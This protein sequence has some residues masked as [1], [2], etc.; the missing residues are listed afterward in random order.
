MSWRVG[1]AF[2]AEWTPAAALWFFFFWRWFDFWKTR[3]DL[4]YVMLGTTFVV[5]GA[6]LAAAHRVVLA[7][8]VELLLWVEVIG[9]LV[10]ALASAFVLVADRQIG[11]RVRSFA[12]FFDDVGHLDLKTTGAYGV[13]RHP[14]YAGGSLFQ[15]G[16]FL[17]TGYPGVLVAWALFTLG[18]RWF[19]AQEERR[20]VSLLDDPGEYERYRESVPRLLPHIRPR[21]R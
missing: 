4:T 15:L 5:T 14:I 18:A 16:A 3:R 20:L 6:L 7:G 11:F 2:I 21:V 13:V 1:P 10:M 17:A 19:T 8:R 9:W 12:P